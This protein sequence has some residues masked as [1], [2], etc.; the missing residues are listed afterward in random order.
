MRTAKKKDLH[1]ELAGLGV[2]RGLSGKP[3]PEPGCQKTE[4]NLKQLAVSLKSR[5]AEPE[6][7]TIRIHGYNKVYLLFTPAETRTSQDVAIHSIH[8]TI[9]IIYYYHNVF[10]LFNH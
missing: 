1:F 8:N 2:L 7:C 3:K 9:A 10:P 6:P 5:T 4:T